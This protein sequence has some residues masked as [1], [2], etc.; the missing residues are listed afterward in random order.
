VGLPD[1][2]GREQILR[3]HM[4]KVPIADD[5]KPNIIARGTPG[6][7]GA[8]LANL[9]NEAALFAAREN[10]KLV[11][12]AN[13]EKAKDKIMMG[14]E[15]KSMVMD[16]AEKKLTAYHEAGHAIVGLSVPSHDPVY[17]VTIIPRGRALG[18]TMFLPEVDRYSY[19]KERLE[20]Q[21]ASMFGGRIAEELVFGVD[22]VTTGASNDIQRATEIARNM[23]TKWGLS[24]KLGPLT[25]MEEEGEVFLG[26]SV[27]QNKHISDETAHIIDEEIR[28]IIDKNY[29]RAE[30]ILTEHRDKLD[31]MA[32]AL[33][34]YETIDQDQIEDIMAG[35]PPRPPADWTDEDS[36]HNQPTDSSA[37]AEKTEK[38]SG[39]STIGGPAGEH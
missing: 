2:R 25:Y 9:V 21:I 31:C 5:V 15:R 10:S 19:S 39:D 14:A 11:K 23:V 3:V 17:K 13:F 1:V 24:E 36:G 8:D 28:V 34:K 29:Q 32:E 26:H 4:R 6:F 37:T 18:V 38:N 7:S 20:S 12:M 33:I 35:K 16:E 30:N 27:S 22:S